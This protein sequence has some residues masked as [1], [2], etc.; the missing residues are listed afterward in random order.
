M[1]GKKLNKEISMG[2][3]FRRMA[4]IVRK[5][6]LH[7][8]RDPRT[9]A[10]VIV[11][12]VMMLFLLGY[13]VANDVEDIPLAVADFSHSDSSRILVEKFTA[14][15]F[16]LVT[17][18][19]QSEK[20]ILE[21][22]DSGTIKAGIYIPEDYGRQ[23]TTGNPG[24]VQLYIDGSDPTVAQTAQLAAETV[25][26]AISQEILVKRLERSGAGI[27]LS[28]PID[29]RIRYLYNPDMRRMNFM[30]P[31]LI[32]VILQVQTLL[33]TA[34]AIVRERE[35]GTLEQLIVS[36][37]RPWELMLGKI[38]PFVL[39][40]FLN[41][42]MTVAVG[43]FFFGVEVV[44]SIALLS[45]LSLIFLLGSLGLGVLISNISK[46]QMQAM[47]MAAF[48]MMPSFLLSGLLYPRD[49]MPWVAYLAGYLLPVTYFLEIV[50]GIILKGAGMVELWSSVWPMAVF[51][52]VVFFASVFMFHKR[53]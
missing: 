24:T 8:I 51:S 49:N 34:F 37:V 48:I 27:V 17:R 22:L 28:L 1:C 20:E 11:M 16:Y 42:A 35:Q 21:L 33:L 43:A 4:T 46:T 41:V 40:A 30:I 38:L 31:G 18:T 23:I 3:G 14:S 26:Q 7:I 15:G 6:W 52:I 44:G 45:F 32:A 25:S 29:L 9:L 39:V 10:L 47:Y 50:R 5:E 12:P 13:A 2:Q 36:P 53:L 19:A